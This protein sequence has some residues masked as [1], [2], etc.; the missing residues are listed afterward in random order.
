M[1][2]QL[3]KSLTVCNRKYSIRTDFRVILRIISAFNDPDLLDREKVF[4]CMKNIYVNFDSIPIDDYEEAY[5]TA[6]RFI[7]GN[8]PKDDKPHPKVVNWEKDEALIF[9]EVNKV[10]Q[11]E[12]REKEYLHWWTFLGYFQCIDRDGLWGLVMTIRHKKAIGKKLEGHEREFYDSNRELC[13][14]ESE[15][16]IQTPEDSMAEMFKELL[17]EGATDE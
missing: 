3:P 12:V 15:K 1:L 8:L 4:V 9:P 14:V 5:K 6:I 2:G 16:D 10:A 17:K 11:C 13:R 7:E